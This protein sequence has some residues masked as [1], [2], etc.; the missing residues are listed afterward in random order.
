MGT[1]LSVQ[2]FIQNA[3][4]QETENSLMIFKFSRVSDWIVDQLCNR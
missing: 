1:F 4:L 3:F 2:L